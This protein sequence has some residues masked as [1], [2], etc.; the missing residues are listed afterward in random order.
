MAYGVNANWKQKNS[1]ELS[2]KHSKIRG[3]IMSASAAYKY[4]LDVLQG[5]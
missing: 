3:N 4:W 5:I 2:Q 1:P